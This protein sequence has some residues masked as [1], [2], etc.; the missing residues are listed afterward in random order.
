[1][2]AP[3]DGVV[4]ERNVHPGALVG[5][6][7][8]PAAATPMLRVVDNDRLRLVVP[9]PEAY[10]SGVTPGGTMSFTV[11]AYPGQRFSGTVARIAQA[12]DVKTR[13]MAVELDVMNRDGRL[14]LERSV[15]SRGRFAARRRRCLSRAAASA[16]PR[17]ARSSSASVTAGP[18]GW[19]C[20]PVSRRVRSWKCSAICSRVIK[21]RC[22]GPTRSSR[23]QR[24]EPGK[25]NRPRLER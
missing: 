1:M 2:T 18:S 14:V 22:A 9:I 16:V 15:R 21:W 13:T 11:P 5:P 6:N 7:S 4:T 3:F 17:I 12:V 19:M 20:G 10:T 8:G 24:F 23:A 25:S